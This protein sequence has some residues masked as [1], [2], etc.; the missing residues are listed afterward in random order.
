MNNMLANLNFHSPKPSESLFLRKLKRSIP[1]PF[2]SKNHSTTIAFG[3]KKS[4]LRYRS[5]SKIFS[6][7]I[8]KR[9]SI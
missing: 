1:A 7:R 3:D 4:L 6:D 5:A 8:D 9:S 2:S